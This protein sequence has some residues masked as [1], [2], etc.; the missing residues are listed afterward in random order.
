MH[1]IVLQAIKECLQKVKFV[2]LSCHEVTTFDNQSWLSLHVY[3]IYLWKHNQ[4][5]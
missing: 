4:Y 2:S 1:N 3:M 5:C